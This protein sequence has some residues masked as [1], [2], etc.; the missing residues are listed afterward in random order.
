MKFEPQKVFMSP[1]TGRV[2][3][4]ANVQYGS[5]GLVRSKLAIQFSKYFKFENGES[6]S[7]T[8]FTWNNKCYTLEDDWLAKMQ[9]PENRKML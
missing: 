4:P 1:E 2:Y 7:P 6:A 3:H 8:H 9:L 5:I